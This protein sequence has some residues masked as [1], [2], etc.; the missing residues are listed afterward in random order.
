LSAKIGLNF[1]DN[2]MAQNQSYSDK[3]KDPRWQKKRLEIMERDKFTCQCCFSKR[4][5][6]T[7][8]HK[9]YIEGLSPW[10]YQDMCYVTLCEHCHTKFH[11]DFE[12]VFSRPYLARINEPAGTRTVTRT[13][14]FLLS[15]YID[16]VVEQQGYN[17]HRGL[18]QAAL[19]SFI[20]EEDF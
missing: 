17:G 6:L 11:D 9:F 1:K 20:K 15:E 19:A 7:V 16:R 3:L 14:A 4:N 13:D 18:L 12:R 8:H 5:S 10:D 2:N